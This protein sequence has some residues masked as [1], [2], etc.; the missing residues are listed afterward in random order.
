MFAFLDYPHYG[1]L[2]RPGFTFFDRYLASVERRLARM[3]D[4]EMLDA[5]QIAE[6]EKNLRELEDSVEKGSDSQQSNNS[7]THELSKEAKPVKKL[8][9]RGYF[10]QSHTTRNGNDVVEEH[11]QRV[12]GEDGSV[13]VTTRRRLGDKWYECE[14]HTDKDGKSTNKETWHNVADDQIDSFKKEWAD[15]HALRHETHEALQ[16]TKSQ[17]ESEH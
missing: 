17:K 11:R 1:H 9:Y 14:T 8:P 5:K 4:Q 7:E 10:F 2:N 13:H 3:L 15:K 6:L 16:H 12:T